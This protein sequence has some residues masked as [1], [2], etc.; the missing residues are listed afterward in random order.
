MVNRDVVSG[1]LLLLLSIGYLL[2]ARALPP[3]R[4]EPGPAFLPTTIAVLLSLVAFTILVGGAIRAR[5]AMA[6]G[7][8]VDGAASTGGARWFAPFTAIL[9]TIA[10]AVAFIPLGFWMS[11]LLY[12]L[13]I[14][15]IFQRKRPLQLLIV[16][17]V[18]TGIIYLLF[19]VVLGARLP[20]GPFS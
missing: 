19:R 17:L 11:T 3:G 8:A 4:G 20:V 9:L 1:A 14:T 7:V 15:W 2:N 10:Y 18:S 13:A 5:S 6:A 12:T 16:P